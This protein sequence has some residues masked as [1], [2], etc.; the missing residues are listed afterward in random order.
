LYPED[1]AA[2]AVPSRIISAAVTSTQQ[3]PLDINALRAR[4]TWTYPHHD[5]TREPAKT[6]V[7]VLRRRAT[8]EDNEARQLFFP[9]NGARRAGQLTAAQIGSAHHRFMQHVAFARVSSLLDL[10][11]EAERLVRQNHFTLLEAAALDFGALFS[12]WNSE[13]GR[14]LVSKEPFVHRELPFT[15]RFTP[16]ELREMGLGAVIPMSDEF[17][18]VQ[19]V[20]DLA[21]ITEDE[22]EILDFKTDEAQGDK[23]AAKST[24]YAPQVRLYAAA[25]RAIYDRPVRKA[26]LHF[27]AARQTVPVT[28][29]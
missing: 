18:I 27:L 19:G 11:N 22:I 4:L 21:V 29:E 2:L 7:S 5:A 14:R 17:V 3:G 25:L 9:R 8:E 24:A 1:D 20:V 13:E 12:F 10:R 28:S 6:N 15:A 23:L 16:K 26:G